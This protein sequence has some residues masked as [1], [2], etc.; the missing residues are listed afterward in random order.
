MQL[1]QN[2][3]AAN[4]LFSTP[5]LLTLTSCRG[6][7]VLT[8]VSRPRR[9]QLTEGSWEWVFPD[10]LRSVP[11]A[12]PR[13]ELRAGFPAPAPAPAPPCDGGVC[14]CLLWGG[15]G[16]AGGGGGRPWDGPQRAP[17]PP[18][19]P[20]CAQDG[21]TCESEWML[22]RVD[23]NQTGWRDNSHIP[24]VG[25]GHVVTVSTWLDATLLHRAKPLKFV[26]YSSLLIWSFVPVAC[27]YE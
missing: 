10:V 15:L 7:Q 20:V 8:W 24:G 12:V 4:L 16:I 27:C 18:V 1:Q 26:L 3:C 13:R 22:T 25:T 9:P 19:A 11:V 2:R 17:D 23:T 5:I 14:M 6:G 21:G